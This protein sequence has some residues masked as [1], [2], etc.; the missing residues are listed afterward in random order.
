VPPNPLR[1]KNLVKYLG[2]ILRHLQNNPES[3]S[4]F[5]LQRKAKARIL[6]NPWPKIGFSVVDDADHLGDLL[7]I[8]AAVQLRR[9]ILVFY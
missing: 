1:L 4:N 7:L 5:S 3:I 6:G 9:Q 2:R 8:W